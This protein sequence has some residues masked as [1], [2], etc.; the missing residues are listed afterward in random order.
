LHLP[1]TRRVTLVL[2]WH[3]RTPRIC[4]SPLRQHLRVPKFQ[5]GVQK[6]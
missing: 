2:R 1:P 5:L 3:H 6:W 4:L